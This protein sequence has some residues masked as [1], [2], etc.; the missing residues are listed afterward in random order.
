M[1]TLLFFCYL[2]GDWDI[3]R[4]IIDKSSSLS[5][6]VGKGR[7]SIS[8]K[9]KHILNYQ[10]FLEVRWSN[11]FLSQAKKKYDY[12]LDNSG[13]LGLYSYERG[14]RRF[15]FNLLFDSNLT[16]I[17]SGDYKCNQDFYSTTY[18]IIDSNQFIQK[19]RVNGPKKDYITTSC[20]IR[21]K[22]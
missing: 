11:G 7:V 14:S 12:I 18:E 1:T 19:F 6:A 13:N 17:V 10:E 2:H 15:M 9:D 3:E 4:K 20:F 8:K 16:E 21:I 22:R 5:N